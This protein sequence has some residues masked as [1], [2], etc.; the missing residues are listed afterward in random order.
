MVGMQQQVSTKTNRVA[1]W[2]P[3][4]IEEGVMYDILGYFQTLTGEDLREFIYERLNK[5]HY[6]EGLSDVTVVIPFINSTGR[7]A[8][9]RAGLVV[10]LEGNKDCGGMSVARHTFEGI[11]GE[12]L[13]I[14]YSVRGLYSTQGRATSRFGQTV[15]QVTE[16]EFSRGGVCEVHIDR[17]DGEI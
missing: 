9:G 1:K 2:L 10:I 13:M 3:Y 8:V 7:W 6:F 14:E 11:F 5:Y 16:Y 12:L 4:Y 15:P 17:G